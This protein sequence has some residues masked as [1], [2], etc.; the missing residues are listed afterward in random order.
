MAIALNFLSEQFNPAYKFNVWSAQEV[1]TFLFATQHR[2]DKYTTWIGHAISQIARQ[3]D[4]VVAFVEGVSKPGELIEEKNFFMEFL[5]IDPALRDKMHFYSWDLKGAE[6]S[7]LFTNS[8]SE[9]M[10]ALTQDLADL[11]N[12]R[13]R[14][15]SQLR[16]LLQ[17]E[18]APTEEE[19][20]VIDYLMKAHKALIEKESVLANQLKETVQ[21]SSR[22]QTETFPRRT[23]SMVSSLQS[24]PFL[25]QQFVGKV[26]CIFDAGISHL[27]QT[28]NDRYFDLSSLYE[29]LTHHRSMILT[30][31]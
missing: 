8:L 16:P 25:R 12:I 24:L 5:K 6:G 13:L 29:E 11:K 10:E 23:S 22:L 7:H 31:K 30:P 21:A 1:D 28:T 2:N 9:Q 4:Y 14:V 26:A 15:E 20:I 27:C 19:C 3:N 17:K 18:E